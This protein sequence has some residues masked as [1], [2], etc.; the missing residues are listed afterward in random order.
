MVAALT[1]PTAP[2]LPHTHTHPQNDPA[3]DIRP[4]LPHFVPE[5]GHEMAKEDKAAV[6]VLNLVVTRKPFVMVIWL[7]NQS[8]SERAPLKRW[9]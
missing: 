7:V 6:V 1:S 3:G 4:P 9:R 5:P 2:L 8:S